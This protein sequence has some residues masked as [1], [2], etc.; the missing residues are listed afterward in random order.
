MSHPS[1]S[2][3]SLLSPAFVGRCPEQ[4]VVPLRP[5]QLCCMGEEFPVPDVVSMVGIHLLLSSPTLI[6]SQEG[7]LFSGI[8]KLATCHGSA[9]RLLHHTGHAKPAWWLWYWAALSHS[10]FP[11]APCVLVSICC[12]RLQIVSKAGPAFHTYQQFLCAYHLGFGEQP[13]PNMLRSCPLEIT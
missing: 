4:A 11:H 12:V 10:A 7:L 8:G 1:Q 2:W 3:C 9:L 6:S 5:G 13:L